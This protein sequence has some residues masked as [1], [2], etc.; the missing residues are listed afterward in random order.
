ML[1]AAGPFILRHWKLLG[2][3]ILCLLLA[4]QQ[5]RIASRDN[6]IERQQ[7]ALNELRAGIKEAKRLNEQQ[8]QRIE[9]EQQEI[10]D[11]IEAKYEADL[12]RLRAELGKRLRPQSPSNPGSP[13][14]GPDGKTPG[15]TDEAARV[16][17]PTGDYVR[18]AETELQLDTLIT[19][20]EEQ[21]KV[22]R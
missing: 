2:L 9:K 6:K 19:W 17:I 18:G 4:I 11:D 21:L 8:V 12:A 14:A 1:A 3:G 13:Q 7:I 15:T 16:C 20:V 10:S 5:V 22:V